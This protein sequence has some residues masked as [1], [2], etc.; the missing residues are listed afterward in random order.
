MWQIKSFLTVVVFLRVLEYYQGILFLTTNRVGAFDEAFK[1]R[2]HISLYYPE[3]AK[4]Q[5]LKIWEMNLARARKIDLERTRTKTM[6]GMIIDEQDIKSYA[7]IHW[8]ENQNGV[9]NGMAD[10]SGMLSKRHLLLHYMK[11]T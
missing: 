11:L 9:G 1:S 8:I 7:E 6:P 10:R 2:I 4:P 5:S 3:L